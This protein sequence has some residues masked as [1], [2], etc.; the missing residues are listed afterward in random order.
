MLKMLPEIS[1]ELIAQESKR[2]EEVK[3]LS[4]LEN[5]DMFEYLKS[6]FLFSISDYREAVI[7]SKSGDEFLEKLSEYVKDKF[8]KL[9]IRNMGDV[10][11]DLNLSREILGLNP[12][13]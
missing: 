11:V 1:G 5:T 13:E 6:M 10:M 4:T 3:Q 8:W 12:I 7:A 9:E 2:L